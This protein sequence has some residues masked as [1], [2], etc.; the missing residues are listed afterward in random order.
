MFGRELRG[1]GL[2]RYFPRAAEGVAWIFYS[3]ESFGFAAS[4][5]HEPQ[6]SRFRTVLQEA[7]AFAAEA[8]KP[9]AAAGTV[10]NMIHATLSC[11]R[12]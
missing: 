4:V 5:A 9:R 6:P 1:L 7:D 12:G 11:A 3:G 10:P 2:F 8:K